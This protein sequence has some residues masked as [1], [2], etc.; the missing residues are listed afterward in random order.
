MVIITTN[1]GIG[2]SGD[3]NLVIPGKE[4][5]VYNIPRINVVSEVSVSEDGQEMGSHYWT[6]M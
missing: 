2:Y 1:S 3:R 6:C 5:I 4:K